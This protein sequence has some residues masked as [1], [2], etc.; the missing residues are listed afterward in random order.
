MLSE[1]PAEHTLS[2]L[3][4]NT[5]SACTGRTH[6]QFTLAEHT[7]SS[8]V[9]LVPKNITLYVRLRTRR[10]K[11]STLYPSTG[12]DPE[13]AVGA[14]APPIEKQWRPSRGA[15]VILEQ[16]QCNK[17]IEGAFAGDN[18]KKTVVF[19]DVFALDY[20]STPLVGKGAPLEKTR[21]L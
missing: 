11:A 12:A 10:S 14:R 7:L 5:P 9:Y 13:G 4:S 18:L 19:T 20:I 21:A 16:E 2:S 6:P 17:S 15:I 8:A 1:T 3:C